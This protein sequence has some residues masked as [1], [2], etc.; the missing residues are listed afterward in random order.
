MRNLALLIHAFLSGRV[1]IIKQIAVIIRRVEQTIS[2]DLFD[3][4][5]IA[6]DNNYLTKIHPSNYLISKSW[7][8]RPARLT[9]NQW[10]GI[11]TKEKVSLKENKHLITDSRYTPDFM[12]PG[13]VANAELSAISGLGKLLIGLI[14]R[15]FDFFPLANPSSIHREYSNILLFKLESCS[16]SSWTHAIINACLSGKNRENKF[17]KVY[18]DSLIYD[19]D[20]VYDPPEID[21][22]EQLISFLTKAQDI[23]EKFQ[24][25]VQN[26]QPRQLI[27]I[28]LRQL[29][30]TY[31]PYIEDESNN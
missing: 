31:D 25:T 1:E 29:T 6:E 30:S 14:A 26:H 5:T 18:Q 2:R 17:L 20:T 23:L 16:I 15:N 10:R 7:I 4:L 21:T 11:I 24:I 19:S 9:W 13:G 12:D 8:K 3:R 27:P 22:L 28:S